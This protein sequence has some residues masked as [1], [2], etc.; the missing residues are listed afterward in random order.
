LHTFFFTPARS[1]IMQQLDEKQQKEPS[2]ARCLFQ[3]LA[4]C[5][6]IFF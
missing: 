1:R 6:P 4:S 3:F 2:R 5:V